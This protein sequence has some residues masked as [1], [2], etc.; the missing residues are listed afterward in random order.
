MG[1]I[2]GILTSVKKNLGIVEEYGHFDADV[3]THIN[4][5]FSVLHQL[6]VG[7][8]EGFSITGPAETW[9]DFL[10]DSATLEMAKSYV[11]LK[12]KLLFDAPA[13]SSV[14]SATNSMISEFEWRLQVAAEEKNQNAVSLQS[15]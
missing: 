11:Y 15:D 12:V 2:E 4:S 8:S 9:R 3:I 13:N 5:V 10:P 7:P 14:L 6:G 1:Q